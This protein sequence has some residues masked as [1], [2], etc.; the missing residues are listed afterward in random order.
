MLKKSFGVV[1][2]GL[3]LFTIGYAIYTNIKF[4]IYQT[5]AVPLTLQA[6]EEFSEWNWAK[7]EPIFYY[8]QY[9]KKEVSEKFKAY[10]KFGKLVK[11]KEPQYCAL[12]SKI[13][14]LDGR[15]KIIIC[16][17]IAKYKNSDVEVSILFIDYE[18]DL[19]VYDIDFYSN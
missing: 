17:T 19:L 2:L 12:N 14:T 18:G 16:N 1:T 3:V 15:K 11:A 7:V 8:D 4:M 13:N 10:S 6:L 5:K 9:S